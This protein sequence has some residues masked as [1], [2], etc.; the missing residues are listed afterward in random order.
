M[1]EGIKIKIWRGSGGGIGNGRVS[2]SVLAVGEQTLNR[3]G[4]TIGGRTES[5]FGS[6]RVQ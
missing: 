3:I 1:G 4:Q 5:T 6:G 2:E